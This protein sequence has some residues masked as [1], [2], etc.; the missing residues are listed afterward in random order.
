MLFNVSN[1]TTN[2]T[3]VAV[4]QQES[5]SLLSSKVS[6]TSQISIFTFLQQLQLSSSNSYFSVTNGIITTESRL[7]LLFAIKSISSTHIHATT[8]C[9][10]SKQR[11]DRKLILAFQFLTVTYI[12]SYANISINNALTMIIL[13]QLRINHINGDLI[14]TNCA[15]LTGIVMP[16]LQSVIGKLSINSNPTL[17]YI[18]QMPQLHLISSNV[19]I[20]SNVISLQ[21][22]SINM[23]FSSANSN[24]CQI[25]SSNNNVYFNVTTCGA[26]VVCRLPSSCQ[27]ILNSNP[28]AQSQV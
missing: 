12:G 3:N 15:V 17:T 14:I 6:M 27:S 8:L 5:L 22:P 2:V 26:P 23:I 25:Q 7:W 28:A 10:I 11:S 19:S 9:N 18:S 21:I 24:M 13:P 20:C 1:I 4:L 16:A